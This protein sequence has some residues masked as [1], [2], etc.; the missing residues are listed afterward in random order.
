[1]VPT[2]LLLGARRRFPTRLPWGYS[3]SCIDGSHLPVIPTPDRPQ[4][5]LRLLLGVPLLL[6][7]VVALL[8]AWGNG[9]LGRGQV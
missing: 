9:G 6:A 1:M 4:V 7:E 5:R 2:Y 3:S 8:G